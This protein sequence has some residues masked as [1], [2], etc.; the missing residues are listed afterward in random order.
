MQVLD[1][2]TM[3]QRMRDLNCVDVSP[4]SQTAPPFPPPSPGSPDHGSGSQH[5]SPAHGSGS[6]SLS[7]PSRFSRATRRLLS[8][9]NTDPGTSLS[10]SECQPGPGSQQGSQHAGQATSWRQCYLKDANSNNTKV[11]ELVADGEE[12][13]RKR[14]AVDRERVQ[15]RTGSLNLGRDSQRFRDKAQPAFR[16][17]EFHS[18]SRPST[19]PSQLLVESI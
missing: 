15:S 19:A 2:A 10:D 13:S 17:G 16:R 11:L 5:G 6:G 4:T 8:R 14:P 7:R 9:D 18:L 3:Q 1:V 12:A